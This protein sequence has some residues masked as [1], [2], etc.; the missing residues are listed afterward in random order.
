[1]LGLDAFRR[2]PRAFDY[3]PIHFDPVKEAREQRKKEILGV[4]GDSSLPETEEYVAGSYIKNYGFSR[5]K[6]QISERGLSREQRARNIRRGVIA[7][8]LL[9]VALA[10]LL[11]S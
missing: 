3:K 10:Y 6:T 2:K 5:K 4:D 8:I 1:M 11:L 9:L 7:L